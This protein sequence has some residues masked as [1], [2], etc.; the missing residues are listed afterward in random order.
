MHVS[1]IAA[2]A[3]LQFKLKSELNIQQGTYENDVFTQAG[4]FM[5]YGKFIA[6]LGHTVLLGCM[7]P[8]MR[9]HISMMF[10]FVGVAIPPLF[11]FAL[12]SKWVGW[13]FISFF[14]SGIGI[15]VFECTFLSVISPLGK[16][17]KAWAIM[18]APIGFGMV[19]IFGLLCTSAGM[20][21]EYLYWYIALCI[22]L[23]MGIFAAKSP[24]SAESA[25][26]QA[27]VTQSLK[28]WRSWLP[29]MIPLFLAKIVGSFVMEDTPA[30]FYV[31]N[32]KSVPLLGPTTTAPLM[33]HDLY[34]ALL[35]LFVLL[36]DGISRRVPY[37][38]KLENMWQNIALL[39]F[40]VI[41]SL[42][43][44]FL[45]GT[46][47]ALV[48]LPSAF[49][50]FWGNGLVYG[51]SAKFIDRFIPQEHNMAAYSFWCFVGDA[52][53]IAGSAMINVVRDWFCDQTYPY[54]CLKHR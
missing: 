22:P 6:R 48:T 13:A 1:G 30:W 29:S 46:L 23:G 2:V 24:K 21:A 8:W 34:F 44:F 16:L 41:A 42:S 51:V 17:T 11:V 28:S 54:E 9:V 53:S 25:H 20:P 39:I 38:M 43:G 31:Y 10:M 26:K 5:H 36:G 40:A 12:G 50:A 45:Q 4:V 7:P 35:Y 49:L 15:G 18:G 32:G 47:I 37:F 14:L 27:N 19:D 3:V 52:G 33:N